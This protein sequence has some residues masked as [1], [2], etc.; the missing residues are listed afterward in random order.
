MP[1]EL[2]W[3]VWIAEAV[4]I[5]RM[6]LFAFGEKSEVEKPEVPV[7]PDKA[8]TRPIFQELISDW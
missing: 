1:I 5:S 3:L 2:S 7:I 4:Q 8:Y 6:T